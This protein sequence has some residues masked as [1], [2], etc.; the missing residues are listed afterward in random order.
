M[1]DRKLAEK[2]LREAAQKPKNWGRIER[3]AVQLAESTLNKE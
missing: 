1:S 2:I 3:L